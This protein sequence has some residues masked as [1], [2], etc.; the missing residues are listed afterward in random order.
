MA[1]PSVRVLV[2]G[3]SGTPVCR[4]LQE[5]GHRVRGFS[6]EPHPDLED[7]VVGDLSD[8]DAV[9][10]AVAGVDTIIHLGAY[11][12]EADFIDELLEPNVRGLIP[13]LC[14]RRRGRT[15]WFDCRNQKSLTVKRADP[16]RLRPGD[17]GQWL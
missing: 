16:R 4:H 17:A 5:R 6:L 7:S 13:C 12:D 3:A 9:R 1:V 14:R 11:P 15:L 10:A 2:T 8:F